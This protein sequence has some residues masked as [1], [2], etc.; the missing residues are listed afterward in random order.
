MFYI[1]W[2]EMSPPFLEENTLSD[3]RDI[4]GVSLSRTFSTHGRIG[5][6]FRVV[7]RIINSDALWELTVKSLL[8]CS[9]RIIPPSTLSAIALMP[10][11]KSVKAQR[12]GSDIVRSCWQVVTDRPLVNLQ[13]LSGL[14]FR[15][16]C[17][18]PWLRSGAVYVGCYL[19]AFASF[20]NW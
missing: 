20:Y 6:R 13:C 18:R 2:C 19:V 9:L 8:D 16:F 5:Q 7:K 3:P 10:K 17:L 1:C 4:S 12:F 15:C 14:A 11:I